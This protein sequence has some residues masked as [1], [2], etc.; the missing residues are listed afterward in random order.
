MPLFSPEKPRILFLFSDTGGGH[1]SA[2]EAI[3]EALNLEH[4]ERIATTMVDV[5]REY[6][7]PPL[8]KL[9]ELYTQLVRLPQAWGLGYHLS[10]GQH[11][12]KIF[13]AST[14]PYVRRNTRKLIAQNPSDL[15]VSV[16]PLVIAP[17]LRALKPMRVARPAFITVV[18]DLVSIHALWYHRKTDLCLVPT[19]AAYQKALDCGLRPEQVRIVGFPV[20]NRFCQP[21][22]DKK[23]LR[24][25]LGWPKDLPVILLV[26]GGEGMGPLRET[27]R[28]IDATNLPATLVVIAGRNKKL[29]SR[30][31]SYRW[32]QPT[33]IYGFV[34]NMPDF[35]HAADI[36]VTKAGPGTISEA[37]NAG[38]PMVLYSRLP[39][40]EEGNVAFVTTNGAAVWA[41]QPEQIVEALQEWIE[42]PELLHEAVECSQNLARPDAARKIARI[43]AEQ[44]GVE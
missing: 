8:T 22:G 24:N 31:E 10:N 26:G 9:P 32:S 43:L 38:L 30:L 20:A 14:W 28:A 1:R 21:G 35:M 11:R 19:N 39:G 23:E 36:I 44:L 4:G 42:H 16:H 37:L 40:Q 2:A 25:L 17:A 15:I 34:H 27:A 13:T 7:P 12:A 29:K 18:T 33:F 5:F 3:I 41:P 6:A